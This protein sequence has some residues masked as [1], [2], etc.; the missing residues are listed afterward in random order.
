M[1]ISNMVSN[2]I[3]Q[4]PKL[5]EVDLQ[6]IQLLD[7]QRE[8]L[9]VHTQSNPNRW[10]GLLRRAMFARAV[11]GSNSIEG[12]NANLDEVVAAIEQDPP[13]D[14]K[15]ETSLAIGGYQA[16]MTYIMQAAQD[17]YFEFSK[18]FIKSLHFMIASYSMKNQPGQWRTTPVFIVNQK[19]GKTVYDAPSVEMVDEL[20]Q[21]LVKYLMNE[22]DDPAVVRGAMAHLNLTMIHPFKDGNGRVARALQTLVIA[23]DGI[24]HPV[25]SSI[26][27]WLGDRENTPEYYAVL[28]V[29]GQGKWNPRRNALGWVQF[30]IKAHYQQ[31]T[32][33]SRRNEEAGQLYQGITEIIEHER[34]PERTWMPLFDAACGFR[35]TNSRYRS[36]ADIS[37]YT[38]SRD[39]KRLSDLGLLEPK[40]EKRMRSYVAAKPMIELRSATRIER[41]IEN[42]YEILRDRKLD[43]AIQEMAQSGLAEP[44]F[45]EM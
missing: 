20:V 15:T 38:A 13:L 32:K 33:L 6:A 37:D 5:G 42:P 2:M 16:A 31:A 25:F 19:D 10:T 18:Q 36:D 26:E 22:N 9:R 17:R 28:G 40:G 30:C 45:P 3:Y 27:E 41:P 39:L 11:Q 24:L 44:R 4:S 8:I 34:L 35:I 29:I 1:S 7:K 43:A 14:E 23:R 21:E 12:I